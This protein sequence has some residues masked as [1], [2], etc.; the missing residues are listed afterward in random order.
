EFFIGPTMAK[1]HELVERAAERGGEE[2]FA[3]V[4]QAPQLETLRREAAAIRTYGYRPQ[5]A[6]ADGGRR[7]AA[8]MEGGAFLVGDPDTITEQIVAQQA[9]TGAGVL[10]IRPE[11]GGLSLDE[12]A[13][14]LEL[15]AREVLPVIHCL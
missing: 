9:A 5:Q 3:G 8:A 15:F 13:E 14:G 10:A 4:S 7:G 12:A 6:R 2:T 1:V 11:L